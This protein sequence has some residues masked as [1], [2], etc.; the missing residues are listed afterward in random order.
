MLVVLVQDA[1]LNSAPFPT[2][3]LFTMLENSKLKGRKEKKE[4]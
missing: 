3:E 1:L 2:S 4:R